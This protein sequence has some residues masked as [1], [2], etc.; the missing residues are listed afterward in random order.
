MGFEDHFSGHASLYAAARPTYPAALFDHLASIAPGHDRAWDCATGNGQ[1]AI[2]LA[3]RFQNVLATD[4]S[5]AQLRHAPPT[6]NI[7]Y[8]VAPAESCPAADESFDLITVAQAI[9][10]FDLPRFFAEARRTLRPSG[11]L[12]I[13]GYAFFRISPEVDAAMSKNVLS[14]LT[15]YWPARISLLWNGYRDIDLGSGLE[16]ID[17][18]AFTMEVDWSLRELFDYVRTWSGTQRAIA[19][20]GDAWIESARNAVAAVWG[21]ADTRRQVVMPMPLRLARK[22]RAGALLKG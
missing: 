1:A 11:V 8:A 13:W 4:A 6:S 10:W 3:A 18:P 17:A 16:D 14:V 21:P 19:A 20:L 5:D 22:R 15:A 7:T 2:A 12:A 9:H